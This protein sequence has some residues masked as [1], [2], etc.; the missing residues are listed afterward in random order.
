MSIDCCWLLFRVCGVLFV[1]CVSVVVVCGPFFV[2][3]C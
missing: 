3:R 1:V 2:A